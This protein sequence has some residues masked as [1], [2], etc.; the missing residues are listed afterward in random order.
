MKNYF[1]FFSV[2]FWAFLVAQAIKNMPA[3][4]ETQVR[5][6]SW[7][8][9]LRREWLPISVFLPGEFHGQKSLVGYSPWGRRVRHESDIFFIPHS[10]PWLCICH[11]GQFSVFLHYV[12]VKGAFLC[13][14]HAAAA[15]LLQLC[16]TLCD[17]IDGSPPGSPIPRIL[18]AKT[19]EWFAI[20]FSNA[21]SGSF[22]SYLE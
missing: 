12:Q 14:L 18:Q 15:K 9:P 8:D 21:F 1:R 5:S 10:R 4:H 3:M 20:S 6:L 7:E 16:P 22:H 13:S 11:L 19:L 2:P 17:P